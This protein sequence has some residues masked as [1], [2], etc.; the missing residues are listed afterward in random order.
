MDILVSLILVV[1]VSVFLM[2][3]LEIALSVWGSGVVP[4]ID[5]HELEGLSFGVPCREM[6]SGEGQ[7]DRFR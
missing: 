1:V 3:A 6:E 7:R 5:L 4:E 2:F